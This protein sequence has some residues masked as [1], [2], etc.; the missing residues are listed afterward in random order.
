MYDIARRQ[1]EVP[2]FGIPKVSQTPTNLQGSS[3]E[4]PRECAQ[5]YSSTQGGG[6][7]LFEIMVILGRLFDGA[8]WEGGGAYLRGGAYSRIHG[9]F[10]R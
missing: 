8:G 7:R 3:R 5:L 4:S 9:N 1:C 10:K 6:G 2:L